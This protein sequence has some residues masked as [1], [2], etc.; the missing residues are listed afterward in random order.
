MS[1]DDK[2]LDSIA[3]VFAALSKAKW[4]DLD[5]NSIIE[6]HN[7]FICLRKLEDKIKQSIKE[8][9]PVL[10]EPVAEAKPEKGRK[11]AVK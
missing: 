9:A 2:D 11:N 10:A 3:K 6:I 8:P 5:G 1:F 7:S 4:N